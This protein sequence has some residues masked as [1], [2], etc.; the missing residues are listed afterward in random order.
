L[1]TIYIATGISLAVIAGVIGYYRFKKNAGSLEEATKLVVA[2]ALHS[3]NNELAKVNA[4]LKADREAKKA[5]QLGNT[6][7]FTGNATGS[8]GATYEAANVTIVQA[9]AVT[10][11]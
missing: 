1:L 2:E 8:F 6:V 9:N 4:A 3:I 11:A 10:A 7:T 5:A